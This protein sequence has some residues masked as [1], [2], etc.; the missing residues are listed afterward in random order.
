VSRA[1]SRFVAIIDCLTVER[2][3][4]SLAEVA[5]GAGL[6]KST[7][8]RLLGA[9][10]DHGL[11]VRDPATKRY[12]L[13]HTVIEWGERALRSA[14]VRVVAEPALRRLHVATQ[15]TVALWVLQGD[16]RVCIFSLDSPNRVR[17]VLPVGFQLRLTQ[18]AGGWVTLAFLPEDQALAI[19][20]AD[21]DMDPRL[22]EQ[23]LDDLPRFRRQGFA[24]GVRALSEH[25]WSVAVPVFNAAGSPFAT[26]VITGPDGRLAEETVARC[27]ALL[28]AAAHDI[29]EQLGAPDDLV[30]L[31]ARPPEHELGS[32][33]RFV[34]DRSSERDD[35]VSDTER[36]RM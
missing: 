32:S 17:H 29:S 23:L 34:E 13:G 2:P 22:R 4:A 14:D 15:E 11:V 25:A 5:E 26:M 36:I 7:A 16:Q 3:S 6:D 10:C 35:M 21:A 8:L 28:L 9:L 18:S 30:R 33:K 24:V 12:S 19:I 1:L 31:L 20:E 27:T